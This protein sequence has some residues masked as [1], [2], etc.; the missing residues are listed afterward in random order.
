MVFQLFIRLSLYCLFLLTLLNVPANRTFAQEIEMRSPEESEL[1]VK[2]NVDEV[3]ID[4]VV[5][6]WRGRYVTDL[7]AEDFEIYQDGQPMEITSCRYIR[8]DQESFNLADSET[9]ESSDLPIASIPILKREDVRRTFVFLV[10]TLNM[11]FTN[12]Y[13]TRMALRKYVEEQMKP[14]DLVAILTTSKGYLGP[15]AF[16]SDKEL[17]LKS[18]ENIQKDSFSIEDI[19]TI[20]CSSPYEHLL[21]SIRYFNRALQNMPG[22]KSMIF[23][24]KRTRLPRIPFEGIFIKGPA[25]DTTCEARVEKAFNE[26]AVEL[27]HNGVV[28]HTMD[29]RG[30]HADPDAT[31][32][33]A[34]EGAVLPLSERTGG[35]FIENDNFF[36]DGI[37]RLEEEIKGFYLLTYMPPEGTFVGENPE[38][39]H[40]IEIKAKRW[41]SEVR[42]R[43]QFFKSETTTGNEEQP[44]DSLLEAVVSPFQNN[45][46][47]IELSSGY[48]KKS[49]RDSLL[50]SW[51]HLDG[52]NLEVKEEADG[53][54]Y[55]AVG[56]LGMIS[57]INSRVWDE[58]RQLYKLP[59]QK[60]ELP[61]IRENGLRFAI[62]IPAKKPGAYYVRVAVKD[63][64]S[65]KHG[66]AYQYVEVPDLK[67]DRLTLS[68]IFIS[69][70]R[71]DKAKIEG[72]RSAL[73]S[74]LPGETI[75]FMA[76]IYNAKVKKKKPSELEYQYT[77]YKDDIEILQSGPIKINT[78]STS[79]H[80]EISIARELRL[81]ESL[82]PGTYVL[83]LVVRDKLVKERDGTAKRWMDF[84]IA[85]P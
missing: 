37:G 45:D 57:D 61:W 40:E 83:Q 60:N 82:E 39:D 38:A 55:V 41:M 54:R 67:K 53:N 65:G 71:G 19:D 3:R 27:L 58:G 75:G 1:T 63:E 78:A 26:L 74:Y 32:P 10:D 42:Y 13:Y 33:A 49:N 69:R 59:V 80:E 8:Y 29:I 56:V 72:V 43:Q 68:D 64:G 35:L 24:S 30:L 66:S 79:D 36:V 76:E 31:D 7:T 4:A 6:D 81:P 48:I 12:A 52:K 17:L 44:R 70:G 84:K 5:V 14:G 50:R 85:A 18:I 9:K 16:A 46:L 20:N 25:N 77:L 47:P 73:K 51:L 15:L 34:K 11:D 62:D 22:R 23:I 21:A 28:F 2:V